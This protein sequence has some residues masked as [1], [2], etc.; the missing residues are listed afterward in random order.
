MK[1][2]LTTLALLAALHLSAAAAPLNLYVAPNGKDTWSGRNAR[3]SANDGP[4][5]TVNAALLAAR[6]A[7]T[8]NQAPDGVTIWVREGTYELNAPILLT[9]EDSG[10]TG[11]QPL[12]IAAYR[13]EKPLLS[14][15][16]SITGWKQV[17]G[18]PDLWETIVPAVRDGQWYFR[19]LFV[20]GKRAQRA[21]TPNEGF[22]RIQGPS[23]VSKP[24]QFN[25]KPGE[26]KKAWAADGDVEVIALLAWADIRMQI[27]AVDEEKNQVTLSGNPQ[28]S[29]KE[30]NA[31]YYIENAP[32]GLDQPGE[33][34]LERKTGRLT[35]WAKPGENLAKAEV[36]APFLQELVILKGDMANKKPVQ[37]VI[38]R[39][40]SFGYTDYDLPSTG[41]ADTQAAF[42]CRGDVQAE[43]AVDC[44]I[45]DCNFLHLAGYGIELGRGCKRFHI[46]GN[47]LGDLGAGGIRLGETGIGRTPSKAMKDMSSPTTTST[48][49]AKSS[50]PPSA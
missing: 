4:F 19:Q 44:R 9:P 39:G 49:S 34:Y 29:N 47:E 36:I 16:R 15:G 11:K 30:N 43:A 23:P 13:S 22:Y 33:W 35:Y 40:L 32:D 5:A 25:F 46:V 1:T 42:S 37:H 3:A 26:I 10:P 21:R 27:R 45:E 2:R 48:T 18:K 50:P 8:Q 12:T 38:F 41:Y 17:P 28:P 14:G 31:Q 7:R 24:I 6:A 20:N